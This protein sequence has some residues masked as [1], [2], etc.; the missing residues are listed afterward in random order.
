MG[1]D[2][3][4]IIP[5]FS[6]EARIKRSL[7]NHLKK[8]GFTRT[9]TGLLQPPNDSKEAIRSLH[10]AQRNSLLKREGDFIKRSWPKLKDYFANGPDIVPRKIEPSLEL[11]EG[12]TWQS[13]LF[14]LASLIWSV[15]VSQGYGRRLRF[16]AWD[17]S[18]GKVL[19]LLALG[20]PVFNL[21]VRDDLISSNWPAN[22]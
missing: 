14:R 9:P 12:G 18:N 10:S 17:K 8:V 19:G 13:D 2:T 16:L 5:V 20:D 15:P 21:R 22:W 3:T 6:L 1:N 7:R 4:Q 11:I